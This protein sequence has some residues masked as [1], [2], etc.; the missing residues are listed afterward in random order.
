MPNMQE[1]ELFDSHGAMR[2][3]DEIAPQL[4]SADDA[5][6]QRFE[7]VKV[8]YETSRDIEAAIRFS[9]DRVTS[10]VNE[11]RE[12]ENLLRTHYAPQSRE[13]AI[14]DFLATERIKRGIR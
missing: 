6:K 13:K 1:I 9:T 3:L 10:L 8:A 2:P 5:T 14:R 11:I 7:A 4:E 12:A